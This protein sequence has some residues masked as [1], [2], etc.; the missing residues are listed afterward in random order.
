MCSWQEALETKEIN[1]REKKRAQSW[2][3]QIFTGQLEFPRLQREREGTLWPSCATWA[4]DRRGRPGSS[5]AWW[6]PVLPRGA[7]CQKILSPITISD[8]SL[9]KKLLTL[10][11]FFGVH[12]ATVQL[13]EFS[14]EEGRVKSEEWRAERKLVINKAQLW[15]KTL[16][17]SSELH[18]AVWSY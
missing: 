2:I 4:P 8:C 14:E 1:T 9:A 5:D 13:K 18:A 12:R 11:P 10:Y 16:S 7:P 6:L 15:G 17:F 3:P